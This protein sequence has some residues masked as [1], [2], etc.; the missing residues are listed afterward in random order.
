MQ[1]DWFAFLVCIDVLYVTPLRQ[2]A[3]HTLLA[4][5]SAKTK[6]NAI[7]LRCIVGVCRH[8]RKIFYNVE[9]VLKR[10]N[11]GRFSRRGRKKETLVGERA[12]IFE[13]LFCN[14]RMDFVP[15]R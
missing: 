9:S 4:S 15:T 3:S 8:T 14:Y 12:G 7:Y 10:M 2:N 11:T 5:T 6:T 1:M 13:K